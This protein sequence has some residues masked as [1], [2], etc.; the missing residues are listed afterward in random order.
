MMQPIC[1]LFWE[2]IQHPEWFTTLYAKIYEK[3]DQRDRLSKLFKE[4]NN[5]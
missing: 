2:K 3:V 4:Q 1:S 5:L